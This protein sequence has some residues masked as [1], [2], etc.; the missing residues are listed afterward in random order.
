MVGS[1]GDL[2]LM[3][4]PEHLKGTA[5]DT[6]LEAHTMP[7]RNPTVIPVRKMAEVR[8]IRN[9]FASGV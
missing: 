5:A 3:A 1:D 4:W 7:E 8:R 2:R 9:S 6:A